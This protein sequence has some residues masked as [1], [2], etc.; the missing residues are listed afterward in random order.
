M[1]RKRRTPGDE[2]F[3]VIRTSSADVPSGFRI[4]AHQHD[5]HQLIY[6]SS[7]LAVVASGERLWM[8]PPNWAIWMPLR[9]THD[10]RF[11]GASAFRTLY[12]R[13][14]DQPILADACHTMGVSGL[15]RELVLRAADIGMLDARD[16]E[17]RAMATLILGEL[18]RAGPP[19][20]SLPRPKGRASK[21]VA[22]FL[23]RAPGTSTAKLVAHVG[24]SLRTFERR[25]LSETGMTFGRWRQHQALLRGLEH[26]AS[27][28]S[29]KSASMHAGYQSASAFISAFRAA[30]GTSPGQYF[31]MR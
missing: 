10:I 26:I 11:V 6:V 8:A 4:E 13:P 17:E 31:S 15:L 19:A 25:F 30:F 7:G 12:L 28:A 14:A 1:S 24:L 2:P 21:A 22:S 20:L 16:P 18:D 27:G 29:V 9:Q 23:E 5:W 3:L